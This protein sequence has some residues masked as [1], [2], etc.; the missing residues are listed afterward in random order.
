MTGTHPWDDQTS[1]TH[2]WVLRPSH[3]SKMELLI[4]C[5]YRCLCL[6][7][8]CMAMTDYSGNHGYGMELD[9]GS[10]EIGTTTNGRHSPVFNISMSR[11]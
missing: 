5:L 10:D 6:V 1:V 2:S 4:K 8:H 3:Y 9:A 11:A 7:C